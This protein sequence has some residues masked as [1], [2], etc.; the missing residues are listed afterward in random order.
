MAQG[1]ICMAD[2]WASAWKDGNGAAIPSSQLVA[3]DPTVLSNTYHP[4]TFFPSMSLELMA[5]MLT[6]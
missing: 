2:I 3:Q 4:A 6:S 1:A 5:P